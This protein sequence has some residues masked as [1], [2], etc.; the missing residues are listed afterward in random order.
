MAMLANNPITIPPKALEAAAKELF[1]IQYG[2]YHGSWAGAPEWLKVTIR[3]EARAAC[4][5]MLKNWPES[6]EV[7]LPPSAWSRKD[8]QQ[9]FHDISAE[10][11]RDGE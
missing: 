9:K 10:L 6:W 11:S 3:S 5:A 1:H 2:E 8:E 7:P 4:L